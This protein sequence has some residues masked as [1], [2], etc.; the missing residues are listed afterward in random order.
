MDAT[1]TIPRRRFPAR[2]L[3]LAAGLAA[4]AALA[5]TTVLVVSSDDDA[6]S[7]PRTETRSDAP[8]VDVR[9]DP[10]ITRFGTP[11]ATIDVQDDPLITRFGRTSTPLDATDDPLISRY[12]G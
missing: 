7:V 4:V 10:L 2:T 3:Q 1:L 9:D 12:G 8:S 6:P 5:G 11:P